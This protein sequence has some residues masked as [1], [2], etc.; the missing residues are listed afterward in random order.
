[1]SCGDKNFKKTDSSF[2]TANYLV[3]NCFE[4]TLIA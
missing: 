1:V 3:N 4:L 2:F